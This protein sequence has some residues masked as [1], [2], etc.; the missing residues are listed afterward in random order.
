LK[1]KIIAGV[2]GGGLSAVFALGLIATVFFVRKRKHK[3]V[4]SSSKLLKYSGSGGTPR[5]MGGD[6]ESGSVKDLQTHLFSYEE[7]E[8]A[9]DSFNENRELGDGGFGTVYKG[10]HTL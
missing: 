3:K 10:T 1:T 7:L 2:V 8:E 5:S 6:M 4:N 9:T